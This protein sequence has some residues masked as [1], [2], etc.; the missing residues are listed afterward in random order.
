MSIINFFGKRI[1][2]VKLRGT[3]V[4]DPTPTSILDEHVSCIQQYDV[5]LWF[6]RK[7]DTVIAFDAGYD[8][9]PDLD[10]EFKKIELDPKDV[11]AVFITHADTDHAGG[12]SDGV[13][14]IYPNAK[15]YLHEKEVGIWTGKTKRFVFGPVAFKN[16]IERK[17][18]SVTLKDKEIIHFGDIKVEVIHTPGHT[19]GHCSYLID[20]KV[21][22]SGDS[23]ALNK[24]GGYCFFSFFNMDTREIFFPYRN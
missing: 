21:L 7:G 18:D 24:R 13:E 22:I 9:F 16:P 11:R 5:N 20:D 10:G 2:P 15:V 8:A 6:Y 19:P 4:L 23:I 1:K 12:L 14:P 3:G 17:N